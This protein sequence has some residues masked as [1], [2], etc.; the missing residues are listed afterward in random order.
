M[1]NEETLIECKIEY[2]DS[3]E[4]E[5][6]KFKAKDVPAAKFY[7]EQYSRNRPAFRILEPTEYQKWMKDI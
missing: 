1:N 2:L 3:K 7:L 5:I 4:I 6:L